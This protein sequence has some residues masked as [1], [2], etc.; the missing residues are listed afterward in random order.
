MLPHSI[1]QAL[2]RGFG[3]LQEAPNKVQ[4]ENDVQH[5]AAKNGQKPIQLGSD[6]CRVNRRIRQATAK[7]VCSIQ[8]KWPAVRGRANVHSAV[9][10]EKSARIKQGQEPSSPKGSNVIPIAASSA[11]Q[12]L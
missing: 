3:T 9:S 4:Q 2:L 5:R 7:Q 6:A 10:R 12:S 1:E 11:A 8:Q